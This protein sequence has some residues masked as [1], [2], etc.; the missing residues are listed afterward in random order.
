MVAKPRG[1]DHDP[2]AHPLKQKRSAFLKEK[3]EG[4]KLKQ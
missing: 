4:E 3:D 2:P 1:K